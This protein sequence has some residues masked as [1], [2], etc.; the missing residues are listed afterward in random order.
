MARVPGSHSH[1]EGA[2]SATSVLP[3]PLRPLAVPGGD[4]RRRRRRPHPT[5]FLSA[6]A[7]R[8][9]GRSVQRCRGGPRHGRRLRGSQAS[10]G[11]GVWG[12][13]ARDCLKRLGLTAPRIPYRTWDAQFCRCMHCSRAFHGERDWGAPRSL[14]MRRGE[15]APLRSAAAAPWS[16]YHLG[17]ACRRLAGACAVPGRPCATGS[18]AER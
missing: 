9:A 2:E 4:C 11:V 10:E 13:G 12:G 15:P 1:E 17:C 14:T 8:R 16:V 3:A 5:A 6:W 18:G 7:R